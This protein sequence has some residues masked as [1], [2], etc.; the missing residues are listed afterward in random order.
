MP[1]APVHGLSRPAPSAGLVALRQTFVHRCYGWFWF[2]PD[3][4]ESANQKTEGQSA[5]GAVKFS[6]AAKAK[7]R[8]SPGVGPPFIGKSTSQSSFPVQDLLLC[9]KHLFVAAMVAGFIRVCR[10]SA[11]QNMTAGRRPGSPR[12]EPCFYGQQSGAPPP[13]PAGAL[14]PLS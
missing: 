4:L 6:G 2:I 1:V 9:A 12:S 3:L 10:E 8:R 11:N 14:C 7:R 13:S 5:F